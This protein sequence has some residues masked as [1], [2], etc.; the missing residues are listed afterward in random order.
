MKNIIYT[1]NGYHSQYKIEI[2]D[3]GIITSIT[4]YLCVKNDGS[5]PRKYKPEEV[6]K[7]I[8]IKKPWREYIGTFSI[9]RA[10]YEEAD[11]LLI[12]NQA[13]NK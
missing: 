3:N 6:M 13:Q 8:L 7:T 4:K 10:L 9:I 5:I 11:A 2:S 12:M 1:K